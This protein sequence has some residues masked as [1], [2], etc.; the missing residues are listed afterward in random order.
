MGQGISVGTWKAGEKVSGTPLV[1]APYD[2][3]ELVCGTVNEIDPERVDRIA[4]VA[5]LLRCPTRRGGRRGKEASLK[6]WGLPCD[7]TG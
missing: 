7:E 3:F 2:M 6:C 4:C 1:A 5:E